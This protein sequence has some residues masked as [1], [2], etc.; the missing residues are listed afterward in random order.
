MNRLALP[1]FEV[2]D[3]AEIKE[4]ISSLTTE[5]VLANLPILSRAIVNRLG[6]SF[7]ISTSTYKPPK[8]IPIV[9]D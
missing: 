8:L 5:T 9:P 6:D 1:N 3:E 4:W 7:G 2:M